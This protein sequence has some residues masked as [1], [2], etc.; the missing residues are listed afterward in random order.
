MTGK[1]I[2]KYSCLF[3]TLLCGIFLC[4][5]AVFAATRQSASFSA[6]VSYDP[7]IKAIVE[8][9]VDDGSGTPVTTTVFDNINGTQP[10]SKTKYFS[11]GSTITG[12]TDNITP[13]YLI[14]VKVT[15]GTNSKSAIKATV[16]LDTAAPTGVTLCDKYNDN[17]T[18]TDNLV[19][20]SNKIAKG[21]NAT[22]ESFCI[23]TLFSV[24]VPLVIEL[25]LV[26]E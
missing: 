6:T 2:I 3:I 24:T 17:A 15:N 1:R 19:P 23:Q 7:A 22:S 4:V 8:V 14:T 5:G 18:I 12:G 9:T 20:V 25:S 11:T 16:G 26:S 10:T 13:S 21:G